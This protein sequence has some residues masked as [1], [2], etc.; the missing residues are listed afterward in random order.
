MVNNIPHKDDLVL[1]TEYRKGDH[2]FRC[3]PNFQSAGHIYDWMRV[4]IPPRKGLVPARLCG[5]IVHQEKSQNERYE[6]V[7]QP[8][9]S[10]TGK[11]SVLF[12]EW[13]WKN[14]F[15]VISTD[16]VDSPTFCVVINEESSLI[17]EAL[18]RDQWADQFTESYN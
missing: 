12:K 15:R 9:I 13:Q 1:C 6:L 17:I 14:K 18:P 7:V 10:T 2:I 3:H 5:V 8:A 4:K 11:D 16:Q